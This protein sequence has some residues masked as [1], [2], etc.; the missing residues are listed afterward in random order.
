[1]LKRAYSPYRKILRIILVAW[2]WSFKSDEN[3]VGRSYGL[4]PGSCTCIHCS[5]HAENFLV[6]GPRQDWDGVSSRVPISSCNPWLESRSLSSSWGVA[7]YRRV[8]K[9]LHILFGSKW[10]F[11]RLQLTSSCRVISRFSNAVEIIDWSSHECKFCLVRSDREVTLD[12]EDEVKEFGANLFKYVTP[13]D[14]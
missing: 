1:M 9:W 2:K 12:S 5:H 8:S 6:T 4:V 3:S 10:Q 13:W 7:Q 11:E 14:R